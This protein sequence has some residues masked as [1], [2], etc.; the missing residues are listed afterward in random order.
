MAS[1]K[2]V[3]MKNK[4][5]F[6]C[7]G[8]LC[9]VLVFNIHSSGINAVDEENGKVQRSYRKDISHPIKKDG[10]LPDGT[11][12]QEVIVENADHAVLLLHGAAFTSQTWTDL[13]TL[14]ELGSNGIAA[15]AIDIPH[16]GRSKSLS[17]VS[18]PVG[19]S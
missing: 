18:N 19:R 10:N 4:V 7:V 11:F 17:T 2:G 5:I 6:G 13:G 9:L 12:Y 8:V 1:E 16:F 15:V 3:N 14:D